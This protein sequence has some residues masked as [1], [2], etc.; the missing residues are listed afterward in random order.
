MRPLKP[1]SVWHQDYRMDGRLLT[2]AFNSSS[3]YTIQGAAFVEPS[4]NPLTRAT[5]SSIVRLSEYRAL[6]KGVTYEEFE[7][8]CKAVK[9]GLE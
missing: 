5:K 9:A 2:Y 7:Y 6:C 4:D 1:L 8:L 3:S